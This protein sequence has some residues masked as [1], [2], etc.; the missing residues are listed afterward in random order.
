M[1]FSSEQKSS[2]INQNI[3]SACCRRALLL[4]VMFAKAR[5]T[6]SGIVISVEKREYAEIIAKLVREFYGKTPELLSPKSGG[7][8]VGIHFESQSA[9]NYIS[10]LNVNGDL[11]VPK[12][13]VCQSEFLRGVFLAA[14]RL[15]DPEKQ[16]SLEFSLGDRS[17]AFVEYLHK[18]GLEP[19]VSNKASGQIVY[20]R[21]G[22]HIEEFLGHASMNTA[23]FSVID[24]RFSG[25]EKKN[26][27]RTLNCET[28]NIQKTVNASVEQRKLIAAL[29]EA[30]LLSS[31][32][33]ELAE[34]AR[35]RMQY[36]DSSLAHL[37]SLITP[38]ISK[39]GLSHRLKKL[40]ELGEGLLHKK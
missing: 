34:V 13:A 31:L 36:P 40:M 7:R 32:P 39:S 23:M 25:E 12:C 6:P 19:L 4:G 5:C 9:A 29:E 2:I 35:L 3:K 26:L 15:S 20:F 27:M 8:C 30:N 22:A 21:N 38:S 10:N 33:D 1:S 16:Y 11:F 17:T 24:A 14:G 28:N 18:F 37:A